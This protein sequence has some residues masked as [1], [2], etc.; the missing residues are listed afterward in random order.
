MLNQFCV[1]KFKY[2]V[3]LFPFFVSSDFVVF[4]LHLS[5]IIRAT[6]DRGQVLTEQ[7]Y[8][9]YWDK[10]KITWLPV[11]SNCLYLTQRWRL[12]GSGVH[13]YCI[14]KLLQNALQTSQENFFLGV[15]F[16]QAAGLEVGAWSNKSMTLVF[17]CK[18]C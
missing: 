15:P 5:I 2:Q 17:S 14:K 9:V 16:Y 12:S 13:S 11:S 8:L 4:H 7:E 1:L 10:T 6:S 18:F 3:F